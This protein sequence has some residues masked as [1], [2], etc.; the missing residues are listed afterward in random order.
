MRAN[1]EKARAENEQVSRN[2]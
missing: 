1:S 2:T